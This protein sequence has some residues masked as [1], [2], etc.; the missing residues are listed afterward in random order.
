MERKNR[1]T[2][3]QKLC[4]KMELN[5]YIMLIIILIFHMK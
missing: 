4:E 2:I 3:K 5:F 1:D